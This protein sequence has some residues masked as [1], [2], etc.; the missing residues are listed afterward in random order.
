MLIYYPQISPLQQDYVNI[1]DSHG[2]KLQSILL[3]HGKKVDF[4]LSFEK[5]KN[6]D[7]QL[8]KLNPYLTFQ[9]VQTCPRRVN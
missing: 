2:K 4:Q 7:M 3:T 8:L 1:L 6:I 5:L 9:G